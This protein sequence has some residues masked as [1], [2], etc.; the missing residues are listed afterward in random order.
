MSRGPIIITGEQG[1]GRTHTARRIHTLS[2]RTGAFHDFPSANMPPSLWNAELFGAKGAFF[3]VIGV[4]TGRCG[5]A[6]HGTLCIADP[7]LLDERDQR[8]L[9]EFAK[10][11]RVDVANH[12][13]WGEVLYVEDARVVAVLEWVGLTGPC[14]VFV[15]GLR[16]RP[17]VIH[18]DIPPLRE[19]R[20][21]IE[22]L[23]AA[24]LRESALEGGV[25][26]VQPTGNMLASLM[27]HSWPGNIAELREVARRIAMPG[28]GDRIE[29]PLIAESERRRPS[30]R[31][32]G[33]GG[34]PPYL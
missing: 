2:G 27:E 26:P 22:P 13:N 19:R 18:I 11:G 30:Q 31:G 15:D 28:E 29:L 10:S 7:H 25:P 6:A 21:E 17:D 32:V 8:Y 16:I 3:P 33:Q 1:S 24:F 20:D 23:F 5:R 12:C 4:S 14:T 9:I 34:T